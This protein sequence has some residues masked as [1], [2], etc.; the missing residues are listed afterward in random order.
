MGQLKNTK[1]QKDDPTVR[2]ARAHVIDYIWSTATFYVKSGGGDPTHMAG[3][4]RNGALSLLENPDENDVEQLRILQSSLPKVRD[5]LDLKDPAVCAMRRSINDLRYEFGD[6]SQQLCDEAAS[7]VVDST[8]LVGAT[9]L[10][11]IRARTSYGRFLRGAGRV[12]EALKV[13]QALVD[14]LIGAFGKGHR[15][16]L[17]ALNSLAVSSAKAGDTRKSCEVLEE[18]IPLMES[19]LGLDSA[20]TLNAK[21]NYAR[22]LEE[23][24]KYE[25]AQ[26]EFG[27]LLPKLDEIFG[28][29]SE[30]SYLARTG[31]ARCEGELGNPR[32][33]REIHSDVVASQK[34]TLGPLHPDTL[35]TQSNL[36]VWMDGDGD[37]QGA[38][39]LLETIQPDLDRVLGANHPDTLRLATYLESLRDRLAK[40]KESGGHPRTD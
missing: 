1:V 12:Q 22:N 25:D 20:T 10:P 4:M 7:L 21:L 35:A 8:E 36:A 31:I 9:S 39:K 23:L 24:G 3:M 13:H 26:Q 40:A 30:K 11:T 33:A 17:M 14:E 38:L 28:H 27:K 18:T 2:F 34:R 29:D 32:R 6:R 5:F 15:E 16:T 19:R 37:P